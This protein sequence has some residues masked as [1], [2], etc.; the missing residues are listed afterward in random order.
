[1]LLNQ[2]ESQKI[3]L[4]SDAKNKFMQLTDC[5]NSRTSIYKN[6]VEQ[7]SKL[8][9]LNKEK[10]IIA[11]TLLKLQTELHTIQSDMQN[12]EL[13]KR[14]LRA[15]IENAKIRQ[16]QV[17][18][19][20]KNLLKAACEMSGIKSEKDITKEIKEKFSKLPDTMDEIQLKINEIEVRSQC[21]H[22]VDKQVIDDFNERKKKIEQLRKECSKREAK[23]VSHK[24]NYEELKNS[25]FTQVESMVSV[26][27]EKFIQ[28]F[29][30]IKCS[31][32]VELARPDNP[33][34]YDKYG[35]RINVSFRSDENMKELTAWQQSGG[36]KSV[37]TML[38]MIALQEQVKCPFRVVDEINQG[39]DPANERKVFDI[40]VQNSSA[41][42]CAQYFL[43]TPKVSLKDHTI[44][45]HIHLL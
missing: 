28:L 40:I 13:Q 17:H 39:M 27:S 14:D 43:L 35:I 2:V 20:A 12:Y 8:V 3:D 31:G 1:M 11:Y 24:N 38:Y 37:S 32:E 41:K 18:D 5:F 10:V 9:S 33:E 23:L 16:E 15:E 19:E 4:I 6:Y 44:K 42:T 30:I 34:D 7:M 22:D 26:I 21:T 45:R 29:R 36:E 25:W